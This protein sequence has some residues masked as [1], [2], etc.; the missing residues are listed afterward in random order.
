MSCLGTSTTVAPAHA[1]TPLVPDALVEEAEL[2]EDSG[3]AQLAKDDDV[4]R[5]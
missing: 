5:L 2:E 3:A 1:P 4:A